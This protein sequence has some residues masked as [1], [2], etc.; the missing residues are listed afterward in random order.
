MRRL[1]EMVYHSPFGR[2][3][4]VELIVDV[5]T[6]TEL[7]NMVTLPFKREEDFFRVLNACIQ[8]YGIDYELCINLIQYSDVIKRV[9]NMIR[10]G[11]ISDAIILHNSSGSVVEMFN[12]NLVRFT[13]YVSPIRL[14]RDYHPVVRG[15]VVKHA[16]YI[17]IR[18]ELL[19]IESFN[20]F[21][22][23][24]DRL[25]QWAQR[26]SIP[27]EKK[28]KLMDELQVLARAFGIHRFMREGGEEFGRIR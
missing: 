24:F 4:A 13:Y 1:V 19:I 21:V 16:W 2:V 14:L 5:W 12:Y 23:L 9:L 22:I 10:N 20:D 11:D 3:V 6:I 26:L 27:S 15:E 28:Q 8:Q 7:L 25:E 17:P 18:D